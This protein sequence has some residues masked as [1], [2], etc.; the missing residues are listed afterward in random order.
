MIIEYATFTT[1]GQV[2]GAMADGKRPDHWQHDRV[3]F[4]KYL[5]PHAAK[6]ILRSRTFKWSAASTFNDPFDMQFNLHLDYDPVGLLAACESD[7]YEILRGD[8]GFQTHIGL[9]NVIA[10]LQTVAMHLSDEKLKTFIRDGIGLAIANIPN[11]QR[12]I[13]AKLRKHFSTYKV[14]CLSERLE[15]V[16]MWSHYADH[17]R[18]IVV[19]L[20][21]LEEVDSSWSVARPVIYSERMPRFLDQE[22]LRQILTGYAEPRREVVAERTIFSKA[23]DWQYERE[24]RI[25]IPSDNTDDEFI[26]FHPQELAAI[27]FGCRSLDADRVEIASLAR[28]INPRVE[29]YNAVKSERDFALEFIEANDNTIKGMP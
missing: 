23:L 16:L 25:Y 5:T 6:A 11:D 3:H 17:H 26:N 15:S 10:R 8:R 2:S 9:G 24:W 28:A 7:F 22:E 27:Y 12:E 4:Y 1:H 20:A 21:C 14:F 18:G 29:V 19:Q 13:H